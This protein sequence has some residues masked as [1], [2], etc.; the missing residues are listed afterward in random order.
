MTLHSHVYYGALIVYWIK[1]SGGGGLFA[2]NTFVS[3]GG[4]CGC[5]GGAGNSDLV[6]PNKDG[7]SS[8]VGGIGRNAGG[9]SE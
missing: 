7:I 6:T 3:R 1:E 4:A 9:G 5:V 8:L 2:S